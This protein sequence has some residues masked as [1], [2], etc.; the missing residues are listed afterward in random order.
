MK[1]IIVCCVLLVA[2]FYRVD[3]AAENVVSADPSIQSPPSGTGGLIVVNSGQNS[4]TRS[5][6]QVASPQETIVAAQQSSQSGSVNSKLQ[7][8][9]PSP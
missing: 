1:F 2:I 4:Q 3:V 8:A 5:A 6:Q 7:F 9:V